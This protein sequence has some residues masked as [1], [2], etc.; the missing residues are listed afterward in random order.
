MSPFGASPFRASPFRASPLDSSPFRAS[1]FRASPLSELGLSAPITA[2]PLDGDVGGQPLGSYR[3]SDL[4]P[5]NL[6]FGLPL[7]PFV[8][9]V[10]VDDTP[11]FDC[12]VI[13]CR[14]PNGFTLG[15][16]LDAGRA[17]PRRPDPGRRPTG[18]FGLRLADLVGANAIFTEEALR[19]FSAALP[20]TLGEAADAGFAP[21]GIPIELFSAYDQATIADERLIF[22]GWRLVDFA[23]LATGLDLQ[24]LEAAVANWAATSTLQVGDLTGKIP[25]V[26]PDGTDKDGLFD[27]ELWV[28]TLAVSTLVD[29]APDLHGR[30]HLAAPAPI[31]SRTPPHVGR[32]TV[33]H[34]DGSVDHDRVGS[35]G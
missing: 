8:G 2:I 22:S 29:A 1:P 7:E 26:N 5:S 23:G 10:D 3:L 21:D 17:L 14:Q 15:E 6:V 20:L 25:L 19:A 31:P 9:W 12:N 30:R 32:C 11:V 35:R 16:G 24:D 13:D 27:G 28:D 18:L 33:E 34:R 4:D